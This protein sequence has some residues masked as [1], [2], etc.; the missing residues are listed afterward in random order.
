MYHLV[1]TSSATIPLTNIDVMNLLRSS[2]DRNHKNG[3]TGMLIYIEGNFIEAIEGE[4]CAVKKLFSS[5]K[6]DSRHHDITVLFEETFEEGHFLRSFSD[7]SM[8]VRNFE[9]LRLA[10]IKGISTF[11]QHVDSYERSYKPTCLCWQLLR[12]FCESNH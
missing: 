12:T 7:W 1:F 2:I 8:S 9:E 6:I 5:I 10:N 11:V 4:E 3:I